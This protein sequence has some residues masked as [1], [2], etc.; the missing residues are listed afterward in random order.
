MGSLILCA[1]V[2]LCQDVFWFTTNKH[3]NG[4]KF[5]LKAVFILLCKIVFKILP[6]ASAII[7]SIHGFKWPGFKLKVT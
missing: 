7:K 3:L 4:V 2:F 1:T 6:L 5:T